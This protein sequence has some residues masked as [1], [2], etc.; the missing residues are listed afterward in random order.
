MTKIQLISGF[1]GTG[2]TT[3]L[4]RFIS[5]LKKSNKKICVLEFDF[6]AINVDTLILYNYDNQIDIESIT[7]NNDHDSYL[8]RLKTK[9]IAI[10]MK[11]YD[12]L[13][14]EPS[15]IFN[16]NDLLDMLYEEPINNWFELDN[17]INIV[18]P[19]YLSLDDISTNIFINQIKYAGSIILNKFDESNI[20]NK[21]TFID[22][23]DKY[24]IKFKDN[25]IL[26][27]NIN[28]LDDYDFDIILNNKY[29]LQDIKISSI[30]VNDNYQTIY[31]LNIPIK[32]DE[33]LKITDKLINTNKYGNIIRI[34]GFIKHNNQYVE[35]NKTK[36]QT[37]IENKQYGQQLLII[38]GQNLHTNEINS[39]F[40]K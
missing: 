8:R 33:L 40:L 37:N 19:T 14:I 32:L 23:C 18:D 34:K 39:L 20:D 11:R 7:V 26:L 16:P 10:G 21:N 1:L 15:G 36:Q 5:Y 6:G 29:L 9:L 24:N 2:K 35:I 17:V 25:Q 4:K 22:Y 38:I 13:L 30:N 12:Y 3:F 27:K 28:N 31:L